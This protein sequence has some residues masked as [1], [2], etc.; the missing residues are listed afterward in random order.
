MTDKKI[1]S[2]ADMIKELKK[3]TDSSR[4]PSWYRDHADMSWKLQ[5]HYDRLK[6]PSRETELLNQ[7]R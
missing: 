4:G 1:T 3:V 2:I 5:P 6:S 7:F